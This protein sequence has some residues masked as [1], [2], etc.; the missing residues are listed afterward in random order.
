MVAPGQKRRVR[1]GLK[2]H[3]ME[4]WS[5]GRS[6]APRHSTLR[7]RQSRQMEA[8]PS[9]LITLGRA[10]GIYCNGS[11]IRIN[12]DMIFTMPSFLPRFRMPLARP[13]LA[14]TRCCP[15]SQAIRFHTLGHMIL[16][17]FCMFRSFSQELCGRD[18][19]KSQIP[20]GERRFL[21]SKSTAAALQLPPS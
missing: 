19:E 14:S 11:H 13:L 4:R 17:T 1:L 9:S 7:L 16:C 12:L 10:D 21:C 18:G 3:A 15:N 2:W 8:H 5:I 6:I 20:A